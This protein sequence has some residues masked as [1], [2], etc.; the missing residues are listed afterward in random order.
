MKCPENIINRNLDHGA[1]A[2]ARRQ[3]TTGCA[4]VAVL[5]PH[6][7]HGPLV[8]ALLRSRSLQFSLS[9]DGLLTSSLFS[10]DVT[11]LPGPPVTRQEA[12]VSQSLSL[13]CKSS[14]D[15][16]LGCHSRKP[17]PSQC[18]PGIQTVWDPQRGLNWV[19]WGCST[20]A[21]LEYLTKSAVS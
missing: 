8:Y 11:K 18:W 9:E 13:F 12:R 14:W 6:P 19:L 1:L 4:W 20:V 10:S 5:W 16:V 17:A 7:V 3:G 21:G 15:P 2:G